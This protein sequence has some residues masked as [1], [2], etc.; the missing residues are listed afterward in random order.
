MVIFFEN[1]VV[2]TIYLGIPSVNNS[3]AYFFPGGL[4]ELLNN[5]SCYLTVAGKKVHA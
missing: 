2:L 4:S 1:M 5:P 3:L